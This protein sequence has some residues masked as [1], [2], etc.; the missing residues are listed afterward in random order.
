MTSRSDLRRLVVGDRGQ[1]LVG[2]LG[3]AAAST[4]PGT[5]TSAYCL[6]GTSILVGRFFALARTSADVRAG[7]YP[8]GAVA[9]VTIHLTSD[10]RLY[11]AVHLAT[12]CLVD[13]TRL[14]PTEYPTCCHPTW[15]R[16]SAQ[17]SWSAPRPPWRTDP[18]GETTGF[19][20]GATRSVGV[21]RSAWQVISSE[22]DAGPTHPTWR[23]PSDGTFITM[24]SS[25]THN[26]NQGMAGL[27]NVA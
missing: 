14:Q 20:S 27:C 13:P 10:A 23:H 16:S 18:P 2:R 19:G 7:G 11:H 22:A 5:D 3:L 21:T 12:N 15:S 24:R 17:R 6:R 1:L 26:D 8:A 25:L 4:G 9:G